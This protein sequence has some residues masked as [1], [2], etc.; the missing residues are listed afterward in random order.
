MIQ[1]QI[2]FK[3]TEFIYLELKGDVETQPYFNIRLDMTLLE[4]DQVQRS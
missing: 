2:N 3:F 4:I 1:L